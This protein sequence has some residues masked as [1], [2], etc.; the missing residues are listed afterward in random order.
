MGSTEHMAPL[1]NHENPIIQQL[2]AQKQTYL[3]NC[4]IQLVWDANLKK[5]TKQKK[6]AGAASS[7]QLWR[8]N[9]MS[10]FFQ[11]KKGHKFDH[12]ENLSG[13]NYQND[14]CIL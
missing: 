12:F 3:R 14:Y 7:S 13:T 9:K 4:E 11:Q 10:S 6:M 1:D 5:R 8:V 2:V